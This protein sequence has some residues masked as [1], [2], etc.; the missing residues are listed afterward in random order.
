MVLS[1]VC[2]VVVLVIFSHAFLLFSLFLSSTLPLFLLLGV[3]DAKGS[4]LLDEG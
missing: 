4:F 2:G 1:E 3:R